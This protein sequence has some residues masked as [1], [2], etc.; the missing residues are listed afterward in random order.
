MKSSLR[1]SKTGNAIV[2][3]RGV[4]MNKA[5]K[6]EPKISHKALGNGKILGWY[7]D[8]YAFVKFQSGT[9]LINPNKEPLHKP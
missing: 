2:F 9:R 3:R 7:N 4:G 6:T 8:K 1:A 5:K